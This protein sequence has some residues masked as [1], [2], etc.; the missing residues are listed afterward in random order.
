MKTRLWIWP[1]GLL[2]G[3]LFL[4][5]VLPMLCHRG[6]TTVPR[7]EDA[8]R[9]LGAQRV[10][11]SPSSPR[12]FSELDFYIDGSESIRGFLAPVKVPGQPMRSS[13][14]DGVLRWLLD[15]QATAGYHVSAYRFDS[16][17]RELTGTLT[18]Q[19]TDSNFYN[20]KDTKLTE[21]LSKVIERR[22][23]AVI[24]S[25]FVESHN[26]KDQV[27]LIETMRQ[28]VDSGYS[29][30]FFAF[31]SEFRGKYF[32]ETCPRDWEGKA[33][34][35]PLLYSL[36]EP[37]DGRPFYVL[38]AAASPEDMTRYQKYVLRGISA[39]HAFEPTRPPLRALDN[40]IYSP[41]QSPRWNQM[42]Q[43]VPAD[44]ADPS[45][46][47][48]SF[49]RRSGAPRDTLLPLCLRLTV[50]EDVPLLTKSDMILDVRRADAQGGIYRAPRCCEVPAHFE[51]GNTGQLLMTYALPSPG[52]GEWC[53]YRLQWRAGSG[54]L[55]L[56]A[57]V[58]QWTTSDDSLPE[59]GN[60]TLNLSV[61]IEAMVR[62]I[63]ENQIITDHILIVGGQ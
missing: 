62:A 8:L 43:R 58:R 10:A 15:K 61:L 1:V 31:R 45:V 12:E 38:V 23:T 18:R 36:V 63:T 30:N 16:G 35:F 32:C 22:S 57:W 52:K 4:L 25:D 3:C 24:V 44:A 55:G 17:I 50:E 39:R 56:P 33:K 14:F 6:D 7:A 48:G 41:S 9:A 47:I 37:D 42:K 29:L 27:K 49:I 54:N 46:W 5:L 2:A 51:R 26:A 59:N 13:Q 60:R 21:V 40:P 20:G 11:V 28:L 19:V 34:K 53:A